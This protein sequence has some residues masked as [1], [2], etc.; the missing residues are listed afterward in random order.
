[1]AIA[2]TINNVDDELLF[3]VFCK[4]VDLPEFVLTGPVFTDNVGDDGSYVTVGVG[5]EGD[6][7][8]TIK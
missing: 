6:D 7:A 5:V 4:L 8:F 2:N 3:C 1:M